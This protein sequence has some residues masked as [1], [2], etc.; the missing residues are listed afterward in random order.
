MTPMQSILVSVRDQEYPI[1]ISDGLFHEMPSWVCRQVRPSKVMILTNR[2]VEKMY[3]KKLL[4]DFHKHHCSTFIYSISNGEKYKNKDS[5]FAILN[6]MRK[7]NFQR[8]SC[9][10]AL[11]GGVVGDL[12]G[13]A[14][15]LYMRGIALVQAPTTLLSQVDASIGGK[16]AV[17]FGDI[18]NLIGT[19]YQ[20]KGVLIDPVVL[21]TLNERDFRTGLSEI[22]KYGIIYD[23][24]FFNY[25]DKNM[26]R[27]LQRDPK[28]LKHVINRS[29]QIKALIVSRDER[30]N[31]IRAWLNYG[32]TMGHALE[33]FYQF[34]GI[35][36]GEAIAYGM[37][38]ASLLAFKQRL[39]DQKTVDRQWDILRRAG[40]TPKL[41]KFDIKI[42]H[43]KM[44]LDKKAR[45]GKAQFVLTRKIGLVSIQKK[46]SSSAIYSAL[47]QV[48]AEAC[49]PR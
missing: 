43:E 14:A 21:K 16:N 24:R 1:L 7:M 34:K 37:R 46:L 41:G 39:C 3:G 8:D 45:R 42:V 22:I 25:L 28:I 11:G 27:L 40:L 30:E 17:D 38:F 33:A 36:H 19:F 13:L 2:K 29:C 5:L 12:G 4:T 44:T 49:E 23:H 47:R 15:S 32:H 31:G 18:K 35:T 10:L 20:P 48:Q 6:Q 9:L 26:E